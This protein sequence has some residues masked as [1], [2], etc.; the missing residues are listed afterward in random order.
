MAAERTFSIIKPDATER[1]ITG[2]VIDKLESAGLK[3]GAAYF[4]SVSP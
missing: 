4:L 1:N 2:K 3:G